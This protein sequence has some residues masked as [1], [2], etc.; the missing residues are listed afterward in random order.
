MPITICWCFER[1]TLF[2]TMKAI[3]V[4]NL[5]A[6]AIEKMKQAKNPELVLFI[7]SWWLVQGMGDLSFNC[8][9]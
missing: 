9:C 8:H 7:S 5:K 1:S 2:F 3:I 6:R 4:A